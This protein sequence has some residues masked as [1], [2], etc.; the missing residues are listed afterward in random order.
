M[1]CQRVQLDE[2][3]EVYLAGRLPAA[4]Q[5][6]FEAHYFECPSCYERLRTLQAAAD[7]LRRAPA[8]APRRARTWLMPLAAAAALL[9]AVGLLRQ[10]GRPRVLPSPAQRP[11]TPG[12]APAPSAAPDLAALA[13]FEPPRYVPRRLRG[14]LG[15]AGDAAFRAAMQRYAAGDYAAAAEGL[16]AVVARDPDEPAPRFFLGVCLLLTD[17]PTTARAE[18]QRVAA[19]GGSPYLEDARFFL[20]KAWL[21]EG[22]LEQARL[23][24]QHVAA[25]EA[26]R[27]AEASGLLARLEAQR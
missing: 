25:L 1:D 19:A 21:R 2:I 8:R 20:A 26:D 14:P 13:S 5:E 12:A 3:A 16:R 15:A 27:A 17:R 22:N 23:E 7:E 11:S 4:E 24:L 18:L 10:E 6:R 9:L